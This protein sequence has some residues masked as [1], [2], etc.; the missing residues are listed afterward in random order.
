MRGWWQGWET[1]WNLAKKHSLIPFCLHSILDAEN[2]TTVCSVSCT[3]LSKYPFLFF[4]SIQDCYAWVPSVY[5]SIHLCTQLNQNWGA[6]CAT[7]HAICWGYSSKQDINGKWSPPSPRPLGACHL[8]QGLDLQKTHLEDEVSAE[9]KGNK[10][11]W[12][13]LTMKSNLVWGERAGE[14]KKSMSWDL[15]ESFRDR[16][17]V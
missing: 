16:V 15:T 7:H 6:L 4:L 12:Q 9:E 3:R 5:T 8:S 13:H 2:R 1:C 14:W 17:W 11:L 10:I